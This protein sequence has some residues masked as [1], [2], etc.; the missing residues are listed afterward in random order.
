MDKCSCSENCHSCQEE[1][2]NEFCLPEA[3]DDVTPVEGDTILVISRDKAVLHR[4]PDDEEP[5]FKELHHYDN[6]ESKFD[7]NGYYPIDGCS[8]QYQGETY[9]IGGSYWCEPGYDY[10]ENITGRR[11]VTKLATDKCGFDRS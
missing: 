4:W 5:Y 6:P 7:F 11:A 1:R 10:C 2:C 8:V 9:F 3:P